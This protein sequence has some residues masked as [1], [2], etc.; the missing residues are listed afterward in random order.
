MK[1]T[2]VLVATAVMMA[3]VFGVEA[4]ARAGRPRVYEGTAGDA[5]GVMGFNLV[6]RVDRPLALRELAFG[7]EITCEDGTAQSWF[8]AFGWIGLLP[9]LP[10]HAIDL[11]MVD[12]SSALH[13]HGVIQA[14][15]GV[16]TLVLSV[17]ALTVDEQ[18]QLCTSGEQAWTVDR[19]VPP[20]QSPAPPAGIQVLRYVAINGARVTMTRVS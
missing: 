11:D 19:T 10:S 15:H 4:R 18:A 12:I 8:V 1:R 6:K 20:V 14:I 2:I 3:S 16:G 13:L 9:P 17:P 7:V 5:G